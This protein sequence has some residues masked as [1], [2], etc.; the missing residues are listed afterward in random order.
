MGVPRKTANEVENHTSLSIL[1]HGKKL[2]GKPV[3]RSTRNVRSLPQELLVDVLARVASASFTDLFNAK[4]SCKEFM[5]STTDDYISQCIS[6]DK[7]PIMQWLPPSTRAHSFL[8]DCF[9]KGN[10]ESLFRHGM[11]DYFK[12]A[13][14]ESGL[15]YLKR[16]VDKGHP[17][18]I[19]VYGMI[20]LS[21]GDQSSQCGLHLLNSMNFSRSYSWNVQDCR[22]K[23][24][25]ILGQMWINNPVTL[26]KVNTKCRKQDHIIRFERRGWSLDEDEEIAS[27]DTC[28]WYRELIYFCKTM[29]VIV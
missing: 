15:E 11:F 12:E 10:P 19:Y 8:T 14:I 20:L 6:I 21:R 25:S 26:E 5:D 13:D 2:V 18:A 17:E 29:N 27:C 28:L 1:R 7:F 23:V 3:N 22:S 16:A 24:R 4:L 9:N